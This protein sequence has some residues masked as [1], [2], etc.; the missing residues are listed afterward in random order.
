VAS[1]AWTQTA[2]TTVAMVEATEGIEN[3]IFNTAGALITG[4][5]LTFTLTVLDG[6]NAPVSGTFSVNVAARPATGETEY[7]NYSLFDGNISQ[8]NTP[9]AWPAPTASSF[10]TGFTN[11]RRAPVVGTSQE[12]SLLLIGPTSVGVVLNGGRFHVLTPVP[13]DTILDVALYAVD[14]TVVLTSAQKLLQFLPTSTVRDTDDAAGVISLSDSTTLTYTRFMVTPPFAGQRVFILYGA[15]GV[16]LLQV[17]DDAFTVTGVLELSQGT[18]YGASNVQFVR[19]AAV[20][21]LHSGILLIG[22]YD[23][24]GNDYETEFSLTNR[25]ITSTRDSSQLQNRAVATGELL[26]VPQDSSL[27]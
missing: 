7:L 27:E 25:A 15:N 24:A 19:F 3:L 13:T 4:E 17:D 23:S 21:N 14:Q 22:T 16:L 10:L 20:E 5:T 2:G 26:F 11:V 12:G 9:Q 1:Y 6:L 18:L 8:R